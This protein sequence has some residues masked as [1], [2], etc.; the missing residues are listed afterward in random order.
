[1]KKDDKYLTEVE[2]PFTIEEAL[3][4][5]A[6]CL[7][8]KKPMCT[9]NC[10]ASVNPSVFIQMI[11]NKDF[12]RAAHHIR[13]ANILGGCC[14]RVCPVENTCEGACIRK[15]VD[16]PVK[17]G[18]LQRFVTD[19]EK[20][21]ELKVLNQLP[22]T[23]EKVALIGSGPASLTV[24]SV[25][26]MK[27]YQVTIFEAK[28]IAG[29]I[30]SFGIAPFRLPQSIVDWEIDLVKKLGVKIVLNTYI[31]RD[32]TIEDLKKEGFEA[33]LIAVGRQMS[34]TLGLKGIEL[35]G[36]QSA[37]EYL[38]EARM[39]EGKNRKDKNVIV[40]GGGNV[41]MDCASTAKILGAKNV[42]VIYRKTKKD[43]PATK[44]EIALNEKLGVNFEFEC[45]PEEIIGEDGE[46]TKIIVN[47]NNLEKFEIKAD[48]VLFAIG[49]DSDKIGEIIPKIKL[50][51]ANKIVI[52]SDTHQTNLD[53]IFAAG[54]AVN[55][56][57]TV[58]QA[59]AEGKICAEAI[60][61]YLSEKRMNKK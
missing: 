5:A 8:C 14:S 9:K 21:H 1:M 42:T 54:D 53:G 44:A 12:V 40:I 28:G 13:E 7:G 47:R 3:A 18:K 32:L 24:A 17:I 2:E 27:G 31:G 60:D 11:K 23:L 57:K 51:E 30:L 10:P 22:Q 19:Y 15:K 16:S 35:E 4:E 36:A 26:A 61:K 46:V 49:Q 25:L 20:D 37:M 52:D 34:K 59:V 33:F 43:M 29:G 6:R 48:R 39:T 55:G 58:V 50:D 38:Y 41:A 56:G 45:N